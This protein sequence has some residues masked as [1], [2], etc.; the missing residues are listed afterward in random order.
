MTLVT[1]KPRAT[2]SS[3]LERYFNNELNR[4]VGRDTFDNV[5]S[6]NI[7]ETEHGYTLELAAPGLSKEDFK[8]DVSNHVLTISAERKAENENTE[9]NYRRREFSYTSFKRAFSLPKTVDSDK[10]EANYQEGIL[11]IHIPKTEEAKPKHREI[12]IL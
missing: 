7:K 3:N 9:G 6:V 2:F 4:L 1:W 12:A 11:N 5:P 10:I 8:V